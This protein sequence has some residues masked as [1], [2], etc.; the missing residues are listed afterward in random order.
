MSSLENPDCFSC[1]FKNHEVLHCANAETIEAINSTKA[2]QTFPKGS[3]LYR[4]GEEAPGFF[5]IK[6]GL[7]RSYREGS[8]GKQQTFHLRKSGDWIGF[9]ESISGNPYFHHALAVENTEACFVEKAIIESLIQ[10]DTQFQKDVFRQ[11]AKEWKVSEEQI[12]SLGTKQVHEKLAEIILV[13][14]DA[15]GSRNEIDL[16]VTRDVLASFIGTQTETLV[17]ALSDLKARQFISVEKNRI[18][19]LNREALCSLSH[20]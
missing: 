17:R 12:V 6:Q 9:R 11:I 20:L 10:N 14:D 13:L 18:S 16:K 3:Y 15:Q 7:V 8:H 1:D 5:F 2:F 19:I 4:A